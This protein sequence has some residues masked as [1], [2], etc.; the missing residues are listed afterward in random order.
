MDWL[1]ADP[2]LEEGAI[3]KRKTNAEVT[4]DQSLFYTQTICAELNRDSGYRE[5]S[6]G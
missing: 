4:D 6:A 1:V 3:L 2:G 5:A